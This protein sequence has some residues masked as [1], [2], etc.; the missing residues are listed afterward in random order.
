MKQNN[1]GCSGGGS[2]QKIPCQEQL[3]PAVQKVSRDP[4]T[5]NQQKER[6]DSPRKRHDPEVSQRTEESC[7]I[8]KGGETVPLLWT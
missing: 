1:E 6:C 2:C 7:Q 8:E 3:V 5:K 4:F